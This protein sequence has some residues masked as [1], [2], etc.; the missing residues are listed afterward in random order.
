MGYKMN[1]QRS[2]L[3]WIELKKNSKLEKIFQGLCSC[4]NIN[5]T[6][7]LTLESFEL[8]A[9]FIVCKVLHF[10]EKTL[11]SLKLVK[12]IIEILFKQLDIPEGFR[13]WEIQKLFSSD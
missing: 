4:K 5:L 7:F 8:A 6:P 12:H 2:S 3:D 1:K 9:N 11:R 13:I 10:N